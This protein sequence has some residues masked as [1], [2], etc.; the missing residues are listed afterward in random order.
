M[1]FG[2]D[3]GSY[4]TGEALT[5][6]LSAEGAELGGELRKREE[7]GLWE[8]LQQEAQSMERGLVSEEHAQMMRQVGLEEEQYEL[9]Q[10]LTEREWESEQEYREFVLTELTK[11]YPKAFETWGMTDEERR[12][13]EA[14]GYDPTTEYRGPG[15]QT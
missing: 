6:R 15:W 2:V 13:H 3:P 10:D 11:W 9:G 7:F 14:G 12:E 8:E 1:P 5:E 4:E